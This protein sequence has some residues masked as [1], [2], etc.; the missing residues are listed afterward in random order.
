MAD[1]DVPDDP[2]PPEENSGGNF[3]TNRVGP[4]PVWGWFAVVV[5]GFIVWRIIHNRNASSAAGTGTVGA[6]NNAASLFG[7]SGFSTNSAGQVVDNATGDILGM[8]PGGGTGGA[9]SSS[10][11]VTTAT[12]WFANAQQTLFNLGYDSTAVDTALQDYLAGNPLPPNE[13]GIV[14]A[15][16]KLTGNPPTGVGLPSELQ[17]SAPSAPPVSLPAGKPVL[18]YLNSQTY[19][20]QVLFGQYAPGDYTKVGTVLN[21]QYVG[22]GVTGGAPVYANLFG[23]MEQDFNMATLPNG[24]DIYIPTSLYNQGYATGG[25]QQAHAAPAKAA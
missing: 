21:G 1:D 11:G 2:N 12:Q 17:P 13:Y 14:E 15:A 19:P 20:I 16:I 18:P 10:T 6:A 4:L 25:G 3:L 24:T 7:S 8:V 9:G 22:Q 5:G 23:G